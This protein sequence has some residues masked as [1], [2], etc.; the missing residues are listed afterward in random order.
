MSNLFSNH[1]YL[2]QIL[3]HKTLPIYKTYEF[4][5]FRCVKFEDSFYGKTISELHNGNLRQN[6]GGRYSTLFPNEKIS[7]WADSQHVAQ[8]EVKKHGAG[9]NLLTF[10]AYDD[11]TST[12]PTILDREP[13]IIV[14]GIQLEFNNILDKIEHNQQLTCDEIKIIE[15]ISNE[16]PDCLAYESH[17]RK[18]SVNFLFFEKGFRKLSLREVRLRLGERKEKNSTRVVSAITSDYSPIIE[19]YGMY[20]AAIAKTKMNPAYKQNDEYLSRHKVLFGISK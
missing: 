15:E 8:T 2:S 19:N 9:N 10:W 3:V 7:Y 14:D 13:L 12:F 1:S 20:F 16:K 17:A 6:Q 4:D 5:F 18:D 11:A